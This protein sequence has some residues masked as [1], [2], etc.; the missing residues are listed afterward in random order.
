M[1]IVFYDQLWPAYV[2]VYGRQISGS[3]CLVQWPWRCFGLTRLRYFHTRLGH[4][5]VKLS[6]NKAGSCDNVTKCSW[7]LKQADKTAT[8]DQQKA[9]GS[10]THF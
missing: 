7:G 5:C 4:C 9:I 2:T 10:G 6:L 1:L 3:E 8:E